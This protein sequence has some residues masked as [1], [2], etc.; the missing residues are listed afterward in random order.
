MAIFAFAQTRDKSKE[1]SPTQK[2]MDEMMKEMQKALDE[3]SP[4]DR[5]AMENS[6]VKMPSTKNVPKPG[7][8]K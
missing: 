6:G 5:K 7:V 4:E 1:K 3:M 2:E 8:S